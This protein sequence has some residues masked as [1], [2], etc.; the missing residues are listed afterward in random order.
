M[1][2]KIFSILGLT[3]KREGEIKKFIIIFYVVGLVGLLIPFTFKL[4]KMITPIALIVNF[5]ILTA[6]HK[7]SFQKKTLLAF[8][9]I[10]VVG[11]FVEVLGVQTALIFG[12]YSYG[13]TLGLKLLE[14]PIIIGI[15]WLFL[16]Y[17]TTSIFENFEMN[18][19][20]KVIGAS[21][22][23]LLYDIVLEQVAPILDFWYWANNKIPLQ[24]FVA[25]FFVALVFNS[26]IKL[27]KIST[28]NSMA[29]IIFISQFLFFLGLYFFFV[30]M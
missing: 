6:Y 26:V 28:K 7:G 12:N 15:N 9:G 19:V 24:N 18:I 2:L 1:N 4:F 30:I 16:C 27:L 21:L 25:W 13:N 29:K 5:L 22:L 3:Y 23:M 17:A 20:L 8:L 10:Y 11:F 14:T